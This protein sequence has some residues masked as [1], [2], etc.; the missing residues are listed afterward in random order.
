MNIPELDGRLVETVD[1]SGAPGH[2]IFRFDN[3][4]FISIGCDWRIVV[5]G[6]V[7]VAGGDHQQ[8]FGRK[9][10]LDAVKEATNLL[11]G[12]AILAASVG[13]VGDLLVTF[14]GGARLETF[15]DSCGY[16]SCTVR[17]DGG[18]QIVVLGGGGVAEL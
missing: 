15:T 18:K 4:S 10:P 16:E 14:E 13:E 7:K 2:W 11:G 17:V 12:R 9:E 1:G 5:D 3:D 8:V 6:R